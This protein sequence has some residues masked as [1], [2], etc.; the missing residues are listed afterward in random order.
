MSETRVKEVVS[1]SLIVISPK[2]GL[3]KSDYK[4]FCLVGVR[5][6]SAT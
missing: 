1:T 3:S 4:R 5:V 6:V 2:A